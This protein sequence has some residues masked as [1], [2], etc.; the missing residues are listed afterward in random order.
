MCTRGEAGGLGYRRSRRA[1]PA[2]TPAVTAGGR[3]EDVKGR[4]WK[5]VEVTE[6]D[7]CA[8]GRAGSLLS[9][10]APPL[11]LP[12]RTSRSRHWHSRLLQGQG[13]HRRARASEGELA[14]RELLRTQRLRPCRTSHWHGSAAVTGT[15]A[16]PSLADIAGGLRLPAAALLSAGPCG[17]ARRRPLRRPAQTP[18]RQQ[19][20]GGRELP[21]GAA[22]SLPHR[23][24]RPS[25]TERDP[26]VR[27]ETLL[28]SPAG[29]LWPIAACNPPSA[30]VACSREHSAARRGRASPLDTFTVSAAPGARRAACGGMDSWTQATRRRRPPAFRAAALRQQPRLQGPR[31]RSGG[32]ACPYRGGLAHLGVWP[33]HTPL[34][35]QP[36]RGRAAS[37]L[38]AL[39]GPPSRRAASS[40]RQHREAGCPARSG[41]RL[42]LVRVSGQNLLRGSAVTAFPA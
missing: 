23:E 18:L 39:D 17:P 14:A 33:A 4:E 34:R 19:C 29:S 21:P 8:A 25:C 36:R 40:L 28:T 32:L 12:S 20:G 27:R 2:S 10:A 7:R 35:Q 11:P 1:Q 26:L 9:L 13:G 6:G 37:S 3:E 5:H 41:A 24:R 22:P 30:G 38:T 15:G 31:G 16:Q 42:P